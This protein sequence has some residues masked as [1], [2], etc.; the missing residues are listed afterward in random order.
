MTPKDDVRLDWIKTSIT[1]MVLE[2][3]RQ[4]AVLDRIEARLARIEK[5]VPVPM[6]YSHAEACER[7]GI[8]STTGYANPELLPEPA[9]RS[10]LRYA[11]G[12]VE[13][14]VRSKREKLRRVS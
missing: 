4:R 14:S 8:A 6:F 10:P 7:L 3:R 9:E 12:D 2:Q 11:V 1:M 5:A 13:E